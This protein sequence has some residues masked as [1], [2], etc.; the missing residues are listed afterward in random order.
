MGELEGKRNAWGY[1]EGGM[2]SV[3]NAIAKAAL[4]HGADIFTEK[5]VQPACVVVTSTLR[6]L[7]F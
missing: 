5:V 4:S 2:G 3:S 7:C 1:A 6:C